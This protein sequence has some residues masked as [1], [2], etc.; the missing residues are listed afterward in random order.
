VIY[1]VY[2]IVVNVGAV[3]ENE[4]TGMLKPS[5]GQSWQN[6]HIGRS[7]SVLDRNPVFRR[8]HHHGCCWL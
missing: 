8:R 6:D 2:F 3:D 7:T 4:R 1:D 5:A